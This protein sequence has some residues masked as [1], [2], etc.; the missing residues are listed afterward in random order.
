MIM[1]DYKQAVCLTTE[2]AWASLSLSGKRAVL[3]TLE[4]KIASEEGRRARNVVF[5]EMKPSYVG[6]YDHNNPANLHMSYAGLNDVNEALDTLFHEGR[7]A[8][9]WDCIDHNSGFPAPILKQFQDSLTNNIPPEQNFNAYYSSFA[10]KDARDYAIQQCNLL[11]IE[12]GAYLKPEQ[13]AD[14]E[15]GADL[16]ESSA[17][18]PAE[19]VAPAHIN[20][21][22]ASYNPAIEQWANETCSWQ[23]EIEAVKVYGGSS[24]ASKVYTNRDVYEMVQN[25]FADD[26]NLGAANWDRLSPEQQLVLDAQ[27]KSETYWEDALRKNIG[28]DKEFGY[29]V[30]QFFQASD[31]VRDCCPYEAEQHMPN[32]S[33]K[34][35]PES[36]DSL[37]QSAV[38]KAW[39]R[40]AD[41][42]RN[43][44]GTRDWSV[45]QQA[46]L[47]DY[48]K[49][50]GFEGSHMM[51]V[52]D[53]PEYAGNPDNIQFLPS[54]A[55]FEG[56]HE[57]YPRRV[58][59]NGRFDE[60]TGRVIPT[61]DGQ[62][63]EQP[64]I[65]LT[66]Q[67][68]Y[69]QKEYHQATP[70]MEQSGQRRH[71]DYYQSKQ[72]HPEKSQKI[73][74]RADLE[75][76]ASEAQTQISAASIVPA[77]ETEQAPEAENGVI[78]SVAQHETDAETASAQ[79]VA[80]ENTQNSSAF[81]TNV[82]LNE[83]QSNEANAS[84]SY[85]EQE[86]SENT[87][88]EPEQGTQQT[89][90]ALEQNAEETTLP[91]QEEATEQSQDSSNLW[92]NF[93]HKDDPS[94]GQNSEQSQSAKNEMS[95]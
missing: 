38:D 75:E 27:W 87:L 67:Y 25:R 41:L 16:T 28:P 9:Q 26:R 62:I 61:E 46:E 31:Q 21:V 77:K 18:T 63:P 58:N 50:T 45:S 10:E 65:E 64:I 83:D 84:R 37:R 1:M 48:G 55:H 70:E 17:Y 43:G 11:A 81:W 47:L 34:A 39:T 32:Y 74:F 71:D 5:E 35:P 30:D 95:M 93:S 89:P 14:M 7:H 52:K 72:N 86:N 82:P 4:N 76:N 13:K 12:R 68:D 54:T 33:V 2:S 29:C 60:S 44:Q 22:T 57:G 3:Q 92:S 6:Y 59:Q 42:V 23:P 8:Y 24:T 69:S 91:K 53:Y 78:P 79:S 51:S 66:D 94:G 40:E 49:V 19:K 85:A 20:H 56:V 80:P 88:S 90:S 15:H 36:M 73:G